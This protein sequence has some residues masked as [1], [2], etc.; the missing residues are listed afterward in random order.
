LKAST[1]HALAFKDS[2]SPFST[3]FL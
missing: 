1:L 2:L 3:S